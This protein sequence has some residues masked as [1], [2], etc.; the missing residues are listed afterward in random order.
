EGFA[1][2]SDHYPSGELAPT[3][4]IVDNKGKE[5]AVEKDIKSLSFVKDVSDKGKGKDNADFQKYEVI[6]AMDPYSPDAVKK[7]PALKQT[8]EQS[9]ADA[10]VEN[11]GENIWIG[12]ETSTLYDTEQVSD[13]D[14]SVIMPVVILIIAV[15]LLLYFRSIVAMVYL[16]ATVLL[17]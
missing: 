6:L 8:I 14:S 11:A 4:V 7:I 12:G 9:M 16:L 3:N 2:I 13:R 5:T 17:S 1:I 10:G 15:L